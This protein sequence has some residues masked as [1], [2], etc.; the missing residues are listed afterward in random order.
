M[1][2]TRQ[3][4]IFAPPGMGEWQT[5]CQMATPQVLE[6]RRWRL[7]LG[8]RNQW[9]QSRIF[10]VDVDPEAEMKVLDHA[11]EP[12]IGLGPPG[13][14][15][16]A[17]QGPSCV[18][19][20]QGE[21]WLYYTGLHL[22]RDVPYGSAIG[23]IR[24][25]ETGAEPLPGP[26]IA[27]SADDPVFASIGR[28]EP[29]GEGLTGW[30]VSARSWGAGRGEQG[31]D[32]AYGLVRAGS[33][34]GRHW[35]RLPGAIWPGP[36][37]GGLTRPWDFAHAGRRWL[38]HCRRGGGSF[39]DGGDANAYRLMLAPLGPDGVP[40]AEAEPLHFTNPPQP[41]DWDHGMQEYAAMMPHQGGLI[42]LYSG[43]DFGRGGF[44][45]ARLEQ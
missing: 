24:L 8:G 39:R 3:S 35:Q 5:H 11:R 25:G 31:K 4:R 36:E 33:Q 18:T 28:F 22:R 16:S 32:A 40:L 34:D 9:N 13:S 44:G 29:D 6:P 7:W 30:Y 37:G 10:W 19:R 23:L 27:Q 42:L 17:G 1:R 38:M 2:F 21:T 45:W 20:W 41:G 12:L 14:F 15:D 43:A 26:V